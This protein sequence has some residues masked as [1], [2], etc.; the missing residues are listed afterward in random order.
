MKF[1]R[2]STICLL[3]TAILLSL[4]ATP[5]YASK[6]NTGTRQ[7]LLLRGEL[8]ANEIT[9]VTGCAISPILGISVLG[10]Y[11]YFSTPVDSRGRLPW[12]AK[13]AFWA[14]L[15]I[16]LL[17][18]I[19]KD[20]AKVALPKIIMVPLDAAETLLEKNTSAVLGLL[21]IL[22]SLTAKT[23]EQMQPAT[24]FPGFSVLTAAHAAD[25]A[26]VATASVAGV[27]EL[28]LLSM[29]VTVVYMLVW[30][31]SQSFNFLI[32]LSPSS[33]LDLLLV[34]F[35]N[36]II[37]LLLAV[38]LI[39]PYLGLLVSTLIILFCLI[40]FAR[41]YR[42]VIF[43]TIFSFDMLFRRK[44]QRN[45][46]TGRFRCFAGS[47]KD[48]P[49]LSYGTL[50]GRGGDLIFSYRPWLILPKRTVVA[51]IRCDTTAVG[52]G[53]LSPVII[54]TRQPNPVVLFRLRPAYKNF[55]DQVAR[56]L[57]LGEVRDVAFGRSVRDGLLWLQEQILIF[58]GSKQKVL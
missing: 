49:S 27:T 4:P 6:T 43:G 9:R 8:V 36:A 42:F 17:G 50:E 25:S 11:S 57:G 48:I 31:V 39:N 38:A 16:I 37:G 14:P 53:M 3:V 1:F 22:S 26:A 34:L 51:P 13:P 58:T 55:E 40:L 20:S 47:A 12:N 30:V 5:G 28:G 33:W 21:V 35:K 45:S 23:F 24:G 32:F 10:A 29:L 54:E 52:I 56:S 15:L 7:K 19:L 44:G 18:I 2:R 41:S 46:V